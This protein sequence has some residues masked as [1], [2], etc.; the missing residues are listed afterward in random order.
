MT[1][2]IGICGAHR[3][4]KTTLAKNLAKSLDMPF[5]EIGASAIFAADHLDP[6]KPMDFRTRLYIQQQILKHAVDVWFE[7]DQPFICD[8][9]PIDMMAYTLAEV[10]GNTLDEE[11]EFELSQYLYDCK[12]A[13]EKYF[14]Y[15]VL[16]PPA[17]PITAA[18]GKASLSKGYIEHIH[19]LVAGLFHQSPV[20]GYEI[21]R[22]NTS[23]N[24][25]IADVKRF[26]LSK[27]E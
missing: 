10:Q 15:L 27:I 21:N 18:K 11:L 26:L 24:K 1:S 12:E 13:T 19:T 2:N 14:S 17:I 25:R 3:T 20:M 6:A 23:L 7:M 8:R 16:V 22:A 9:T 5:I 4:G